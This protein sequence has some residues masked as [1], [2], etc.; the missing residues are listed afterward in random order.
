MMVSGQDQSEVSWY[1]EG[2]AGDGRTWFIDLK[3]LPFLIGRQVGAHLRLSASE[4]SRRHAIIFSRDGELWVQEF[5]S[6]NGTFVNRQRVEG[7]QR[8]RN[9]DILHFGPL[10]FR[11]VYSR[12]LTAEESSVEDRL[13]A[14]S[15]PRELPR[16]FVNCVAE[17]DDLLRRPSV[18]PHFQPIV[19]LADQ[20]IVGYELL[21]R[22][23]AVDL[24]TAPW[25]LLQIAQRLHKDIELSELFRWVGIQQANLFNLQQRLFVN[26]VPA[27]MDLRRLQPS[28]ESLRLQMPN[29]PLALEVHETAMTELVLMRNLHALLTEMDIQL[30][31]DDFGAGQAR[32]RELITVPP[33]YLKFDMA[34]IRNIHQQPPRA[35]QALQSLVAMARD[36]GVS[37]V[38]EG[39][40]CQAECEVCT[41]LGFNLAQGYYLGRPAP[42]LA[43]TVEPADDG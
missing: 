19:H 1:L 15:V 24:P 29:L 14:V 40:E 41:Q 36:L 5:G 34:L 9:G 43:S 35:R 7:E 38:A 4:V 20:Q 10:E 18:V 13:T 22:G 2:F 31:Y 11:L 37:T 39:I 26:T 30:A 16:G 42:Y 17:F 12:P 6:T 21:G 23:C 27:E 8:L 25:P 32:L 33:D 28:L 3:P